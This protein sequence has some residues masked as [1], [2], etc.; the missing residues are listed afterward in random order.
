MPESCGRVL[1][2]QEMSSPGKSVG[3]R[4]KQQR[5]PRVSEKKRRDDDRDPE[6]RTSSVHQ[7]I[8]ELRVLLHVEG[9]EFVIGLELAVAHELTRRVRN[10]LAHTS[11]IS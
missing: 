3:D 8:R 1:L 7:A 9:E 6:R 11:S 4:K 10:M 5:V 2:Q